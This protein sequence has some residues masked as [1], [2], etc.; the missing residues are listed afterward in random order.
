MDDTRLHSVF[1]SNR[2]ALLPS[3]MEG[4]SP[5]N[6]FGF[7]L[8]YGYCP[9]VCDTLMSANI[10]AG[11]DKLNLPGVIM[12]KQERKIFNWD[13]STQLMDTF[14]NSDELAETCRTHAA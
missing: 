8:P 3:K 14:S 7:R 13:E 2:A 10:A 4:K 1:N 5:D 11:V 9:V 6:L 12:A